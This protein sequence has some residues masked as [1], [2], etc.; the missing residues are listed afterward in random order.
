MTQQR[1]EA[2]PLS[3]GAGR[4]GTLCNPRIDGEQRDAF[5][6]SLCDQQPIEGS[7]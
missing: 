2:E 6:L 1:P 4:P 7:L 3:N 5:D